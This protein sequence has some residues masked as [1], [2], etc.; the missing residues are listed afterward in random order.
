MK[1]TGARQWLA[2]LALASVR[3]YQIFLGPFFGGSCKFHPSCSR[4]TYEAIERFGARRGAWLGLKR[5]LRC[6]PFSAGGY[7]PVPD[8]W[9]SETRGWKLEGA[10]PTAGMHDERCDKLDF[11]EV[12]LREGCDLQKTKETAVSSS[13]LLVGM[14]TNG[15]FQRAAK[16]APFAKHAP[17]AKRAQ[18]K[19]D[20][21]NDNATS[22]QMPLRE[23]APQTTN[24][25]SR[26][27]IAR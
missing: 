12:S 14:T 8:F 9:K 18:G 25:H 23:R 4:Y 7:D 10:T 1:R 27:E 15:V 19:Q 13:R 17:F 16:A 26:A 24:R 22:F 11:A 5:F 2:W 6:R 21:R 20:E 3:A